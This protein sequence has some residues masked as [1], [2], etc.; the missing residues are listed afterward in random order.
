[1]PALPLV[2]EGTALQR[3]G[4]GQG[5][6][7]GGAQRQVSCPGL[8]PQLCPHF[9]GH[10]AFLAP[11]GGQQRLILQE[12]EGKVD[13]VALDLGELRPGQRWADCGQGLHDHVLPERP[14]RACGIGWQAAEDLWV[15]GTEASGAWRPSAKSPR[16][17]R[18]PHHIPPR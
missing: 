9:E 12:L 13:Q 14:E 10:H 4:W 11:Q 5:A 8:K 18:S 2:S 16:C 1:M 3:E 7:L 15:G 17:P 6:S